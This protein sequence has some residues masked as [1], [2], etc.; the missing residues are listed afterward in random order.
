MKEEGAGREE[1]MNDDLQARIRG[2]IN[3]SLDTWH[4]YNYK[5]PDT[6]SITPIIGPLYRVSFT[7]TTHVTIPVNA[8]YLDTEGTTTLFLDADTLAWVTESRIAALGGNHDE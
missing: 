4:F 7:V 1:K 5:G 8:L 2:A 3:W 6:V